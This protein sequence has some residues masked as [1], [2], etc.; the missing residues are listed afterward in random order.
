MSLYF[1]QVLHQYQNE[2][3]SVIPGEHSQ[4]Y[5]MNLTCIEDLHHALFDRGVSDK[6]VAITY[7]IIKGVLSM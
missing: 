7:N 1:S 5:L 3:R 6:V 2:H 4:L